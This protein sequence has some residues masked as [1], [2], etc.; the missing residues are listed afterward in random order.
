MRRPF[1]GLAVAL[2]IVTLA[3]SGQAYAQLGGVGGVGA[4]PF[5]FYYG[6]Y[7]PHAAAMAA[8]P[9]PMDGIN[10]NALQRQATAQTD[11]ATLFD[12][13]SP[14]GDEDSDPFSPY[15]NK[16]GGERRAKT[17]TG[18]N[19]NS[20]VRGTGPSMYYN[21]TARYFP[22][23][24]VGRGPNKNLAHLRGNRGGGMGMGGMGMPSMP[25]PR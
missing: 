10:Q 15:T 16:R 24:K 14:Y 11:R 6:Y 4:D 23:L 3:P 8:Q 13:I 20:N 1:L 9:T 17:V 21:R 22:T 19:D 18:L 5:S 25:G 7:L 2:A 12:P